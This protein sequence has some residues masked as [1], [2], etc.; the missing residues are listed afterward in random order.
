MS[1]INYV[2]IPHPPRKDIIIA[3]QLE[4]ML[5]YQKMNN[6]KRMCMTNAQILR[7]LISGPT[8]SIKVTVIPV[9]CI[10]AQINIPDTLSICA[11]HLV[12]RCGDIIIDPSYEYSHG[13]T[14]K[15]YFYSI[16]EFSKFAKKMASSPHITKEHIKTFVS[17]H[18]T[19]EKINSGGCYTTDKSY[20]NNVFDY[21]ENK[22]KKW[23]NAR[24]FNI[25]KIFVGGAITDY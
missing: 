19:A 13:F 4:L 20:Y 14:N 3:K 7:D 8:N 2:R 22:M 23:G 24:V 5:K 16:G 9:I 12:V 17:L 25:N 18:D 11:G 10:G 15:K 1:N 21:I 6:I